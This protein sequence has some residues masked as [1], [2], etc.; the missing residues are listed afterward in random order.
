MK[1]P[2]VPS[3]GDVRSRW[4]RE[5]SGGR[6]AHRAAAGDC[7]YRTSPLL[8]SRP[9]ASIVPVLEAVAS[10]GGQAAEDLRPHGTVKPTAADVFR[11]GITTRVGVDCF[12]TDWLARS[13][14]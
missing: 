12:G 5:T 1:G 14:P 11:R 6:A 4:K 7:G 9:A 2:L 13:F 8:G 3:L 10:R